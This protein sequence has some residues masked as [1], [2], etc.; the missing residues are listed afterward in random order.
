MAAAALL[1]ALSVPTIRVLFQGSAFTA[2]DTVGSASALFFYAFSIPIWGVLQVITRGFY[3]R[4]EMWLPVIVGTASTLAAV[5]IY[6][7]L[8]AAFDIRGVA[9]ASV[10][11]L[12]LYTAVLAWEWYRRTGTAELGPLMDSVTRAVP[13]AVVG[14][15]AA[16]GAA[17]LVGTAIDPAGWIG[18][19][20][21]L[22]AGA[23]A[24]AGVALVGGSALHD[25]ES[26]RG[27]RA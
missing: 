4:R 18:S 2:A 11:S 8:S 14:G 25:L 12:G 7:G 17:W 3:A 16:W 27:V 19:V 6:F 23:A 10:L 1:A 5:P 24:F 9:L 26:R 13:L 20:A 15:L 22:I 21:A